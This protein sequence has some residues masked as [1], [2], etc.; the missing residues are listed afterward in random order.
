MIANWIGIAL[1]GVL[2]IAGL[3]LTIFG[4]GGTFLIFV[5]AVLY[6]LVVWEL[7]IS[8]LSLTSLLVL[9]ITG[10]LLEWVISARHSKKRGVRTE[11]T[12]G[13]LAG[14]LIGAAVLSAAGIIGTIIGLFGGAL[15][16][17]YIAEYVKYKDSKKAIHA[18]KTALTGRIQISFM[19]TS[20]A[21][22]QIIIIIRA[23]I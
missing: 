10:E 20:I 2:S 19:K 23:I 11:G 5:S 16:G 13:T 3:A 12:I 4:I 8:L 21:I 7:N 9:A 1:I 14:G 15:L 22:I 6:D 17:A 18:A